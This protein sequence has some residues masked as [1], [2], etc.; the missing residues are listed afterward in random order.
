M[1]WNEI[2]KF[3]DFGEPNVQTLGLVSYVSYI[4]SEEEKY[5]L[6]L[7]PE[8]QRGQVWTERQQSRY[9]EFLLRGG[10]TGRDMYFNW[11]QN[12]NTYVCVDGLQRTTA[13]EKFINNELLVFGQYFRDF[14]FPRHIIGNMP[15]PD[16]SIRVHTNSLSSQEDVL[17]WY[18]DLNS[19]GSSHTDDEIERVKKII[20]N[21]RREP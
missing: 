4:K 17:Q 14:D 8:F 16:Y 9:I 7:N 2:P 20:D 11:N 6:Q 21:L 10:K 12:D 1:K 18:I 15:L 13:I 3:K 5:D 19:G